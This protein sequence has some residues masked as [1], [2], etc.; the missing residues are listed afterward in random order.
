MPRRHLWLRD[1]FLQIFLGGLTCLA[2]VGVATF[3]RLLARFGLSRAL[4]EEKDELI[5]LVTLKDMVFRY[6]G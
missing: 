6:E 1:R 3:G 2:L 5:G 4:V